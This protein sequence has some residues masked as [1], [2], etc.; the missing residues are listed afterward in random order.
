MATQEAGSTFLWQRES[1]AFLALSLE[2][3]MQLLGSDLLHVDSEMEVRD[4][5][6]AK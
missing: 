6:F 5:C 2:P 1:A 3:L 4:Q